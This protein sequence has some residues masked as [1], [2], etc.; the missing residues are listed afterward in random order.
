MTVKKRIQFSPMVSSLS[1]PTGG[2]SSDL[3]G[4]AKMQAKP[5]VAVI[6]IGSTPI[7]HINGVDFFG[8]LD[9]LVKTLPL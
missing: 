4:Y 3:L 9:T 8:A 2:V 1:T 6:T 7:D 5:G